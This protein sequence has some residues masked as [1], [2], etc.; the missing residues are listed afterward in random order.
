MMCMACAPPSD[1][2]IAERKALVLALQ[3]EFTTPGSLGVGVN[4]LKD[5]LCCDASSASKGE[6]AM[7]VK[8]KLMNRCIPVN[9]HHFIR[10]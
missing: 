10:I 8:V 3:L 7:Q 5:A 1:P 6:V 2:R 9:K 4:E